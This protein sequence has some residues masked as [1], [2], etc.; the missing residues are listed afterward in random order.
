MINDR[1]DPPAESYWAPNPARPW[2]PWTW[3]KKI[4]VRVLFPP[5]LIWDALK[6]TVNFFSGRAVGKRV[7]AAQTKITPDKRK[8]WLENAETDL[9]DTTLK[10]VRVITHDLAILDTIEIQNKNSFNQPKSQQKYII[11]MTGNA[12]CY[13]VITAEMAKDAKKL[14]FTVI[15]FNFRGVGDSRGTPLSMRDLI[16]DGIAQVQRLLAK[17]I[18]PDNITLKGH[19]L[20]GAI[21]TVV[22]KHFHDQGIRIRVFNDRS[23]SS[24]TNV[25]IGRLRRLFTGHHHTG[26]HESFLGRVMG[27]IAKPFLK[28]AFYATQWEIDADDAFK[29]LPDTH[30]DYVVIR[31]HEEH[32]KQHHL[33]RNSRSGDDTMITYYASLHLAFKPVRRR[34]K[35]LLKKAIADLEARQNRIPHEDQLLETLRTKLHLLKERKVC[36]GPQMERGSN[37]RLHDLDL[38]VLSFRARVHTNHLTADTFFRRFAT[39]TAT[40]TVEDCI[41]KVCR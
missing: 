20:G 13:E 25:L 12:G 19:S 4:A 6:F 36:G 11:N 30:K 32:R 1:H 33:D 37:R 31:S 3:F 2:G 22:T 8:R 39:G 21:A 40:L 27:W 35:N 14:G 9:N 15:G 38:S 23:F 29:A 5:L 24:L 17:G 7:L 16:T 28:M 18:P 26:H 34:K 41:P 10:R